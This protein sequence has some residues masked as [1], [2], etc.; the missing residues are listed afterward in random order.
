MLQVVRV[1]VGGYQAVDRPAETA[2]QT[3]GENGL[4]QGALKQSVLFARGL[5]KARVNRAVLTFELVGGRF[6]RRCLC[7]RCFR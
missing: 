7:L 3:V 1:D 6:L 4:D 2:V 5:L